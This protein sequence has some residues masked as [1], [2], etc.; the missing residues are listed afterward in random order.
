MGRVADVVA[1]LTSAG[2]SN[3]DDDQG[4]IQ[5]L[6]LA[7]VGAPAHSTDTS[8]TGGTHFTLV[9]PKHTPPLFQLRKGTYLTL[10]DISLPS[11]LQVAATQ[12]H[13]EEAAQEARAGSQPLSSAGGCSGSGEVGQFQRGRIV[14]D[15]RC[16]LLQTHAGEDV[17]DDGG[18][19]LQWDEAAGRWANRVTNTRPWL[20][21]ANGG[22]LMKVRD[23]VEG[24]AERVSHSAMSRSIAA[25]LGAGHIS[26]GDEAF[27]PA[28]SPS[29]C[30]HVGHR[31]YRALCHALLALQAPQRAAMEVC[32]A[33]VA[34]ESR[35]CDGE[36]ALVGLAPP[37][38]IS[39]AGALL[40]AVPA[41]GG[42]GG[43][44]CALL[45]LPGAV[46]LLD[47]VSAACVAYARA[48]L[49]AATVVTPTCGV[50]Y[51]SCG[52]WLAAVLI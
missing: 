43:G 39:I 30:Y 24:R 48:A 52:V 44:V 4:C 45:A 1:A 8:D 28:S 20:F 21:H 14:L 13:G 37:S 7:Q 31:S 47:G 46:L 32:A 9:R 22:L 11:L 50:S 29:S 3:T 5:R 35:A 12:A 27:S 33:P 23:R 2:A 26:Y 15:Y 38:R 17:H 18:E 36:A 42:G 16:E 49:R 41:G 51:L 34:G 25:K 40:R 19:A 6:F 10:V